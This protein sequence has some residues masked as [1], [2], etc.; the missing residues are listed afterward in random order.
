MTSP[1]AWIV[2]AIATM[3]FFYDY[4]QQ[5]AP[6]AMEKELT[7]HFHA[8]A[9]SIG[10]IASVY[11][12]SYA[13]MQIPI[14]IMADR[15]GPHRP[16]AI[17]AI[18]S[19]CAGAIFTFT[20]TPVEAIT[21]RILLGA[22]TGFSFVSC[23]KLVDNWFPPQKFATMVGLT[24]I[25][26]MSGAV[27]GEAPLTEAVSVIGWKY[28]MLGIAG[29]G[30][31]IVILIFTFIKDR[32]AGINQKKDTTKNISGIKETLSVLK[33]ILHNPHAWFNAG[34]A[35]TINMVYT[36]FGALW[37]TVYIAQL[38]KISTTD[39]AF[40][41]SMLFIGAIPGSFF[42]GW[43]SDKI[44]KRGFPMI[45]ASTGG[46]ACMS[47]VVYIPEIP[48][49]VMYP[50]MFILGFSC[51][52]NVVAYAYGNDI[53]PEGADGISL[54]FVNTFLIGGSA[55]AQPVIGWLLEKSSHEAISFTI[56]EFRYSFTVL[57]A[58]KAIALIAAVIVTKKESK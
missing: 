43:F 10:F 15:F 28:T 12:Y 22:A 35:A 53:S 33:N 27:I 7:I 5:V 55:L 50:L 34:Y 24:N 14:G 46:L 47:A 3:Y 40:V 9:A 19:S 30:A 31:L 57:V 26:G 21:I 58:A 17:A 18:I 38:Y 8:N 1:R 29:F 37:G 25:V 56:P 49:P 20:S 44:G 16:L 2:W 13:L 41:V 45:I 4:V 11:F 23:L 32:P 51:A 6:G 52:G 54:G 39:A 48:M 42:F 36:G